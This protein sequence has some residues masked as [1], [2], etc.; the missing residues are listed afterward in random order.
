ML[1]KF[2][3]LVPAVSSPTQIPW[4]KEKEKRKKREREDISSMQPVVS[5]GLSYNHYVMRESLH[6]V[7]FALSY[8]TEYGS[9]CPDISG[10]RFRVVC[11]WLVSFLSFLIFIYIFFS[12]WIEYEHFEVLGFKCVFMELLPFEV[13]CPCTF[14]SGASSPHVHT[15][16]L[17]LNQACTRTCAQT[18][19]HT[20]TLHHQETPGKAKLT[21]MNKHVF[22]GSHSVSCLFSSCVHVNHCYCCCCT[23]VVLFCFCTESVK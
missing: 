9:W 7:D 13:V 3:I 12:F 19:A 5:S 14:W 22:T 8:K 11:G 23:V 2:S 20:H 18:H 17:P 10:C 1:G 6:Q 4:Q 21:P 15:H 16:R